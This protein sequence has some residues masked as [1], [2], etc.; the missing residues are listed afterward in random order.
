MNPNL[1]PNITYKL[2]GLE[3]L[4]RQEREFYGRFIRE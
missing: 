1:Y 2:E 3:A 4:I